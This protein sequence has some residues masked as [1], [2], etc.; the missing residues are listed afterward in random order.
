MKQDFVHV[1]ELKGDTR[2]GFVKIS[3]S[4]FIVLLAFGV[5]CTGV[6]SEET[7]AQQKFCFLSQSASVVE[8]TIRLCFAV[9]IVVI[10]IVIIF[11]IA[12]QNQELIA[13]NKIMV[14]KIR[15]FHVH[16]F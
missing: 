12:V 5:F 3:L 4:V 15:L 7:F 11:F 6:Y 10:F 14:A 8:F 16:F 1:R 2:Y 13:E 9:I